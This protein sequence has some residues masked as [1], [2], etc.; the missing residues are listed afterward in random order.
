VTVLRDT[1]TDALDTV[2]PFY[3]RL[4]LDGGLT[5]QPLQRMPQYVRFYGREMADRLPG[6]EQ[7]R[8]LNQRAM[9]SP[10]FAQAMRERAAQPGFY[11]LLHR[12]T[13]GRA[14]C[15]W[16]ENGLFLGH[17]GALASCCYIKDSARFGL[18][19]PD[20]PLVAAA[21]RRRAMADELARGRIPPACQGCDTALR[22]AGAALAR[23]PTA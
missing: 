1:A 16:L 14:A 18:A 21:T 13:A 7:T 5:I 19:P 23:R 20:A 6:P 3:R 11:E 8:Q 17:D 22:V 15:P 2:L 12:S 4:G 9:A 10:D